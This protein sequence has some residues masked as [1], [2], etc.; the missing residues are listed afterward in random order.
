MIS[1]HL[2]F[3]VF[4]LLVYSS[5]CIAFGVGVFLVVMFE[6]L[7]FVY[8]V[9]TIRHKFTCFYLDTHTRSSNINSQYPKK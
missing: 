8:R 2:W 6:T 3:E 5:F 1:T 4:N 9:I 7:A